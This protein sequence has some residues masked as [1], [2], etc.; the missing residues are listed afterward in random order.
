MINPTAGCNTVLQLN[1]GE[2]KSSVIAP[3]VASALSDGTKLVRVVVLKSLAGQM[4]Q[5]LAERLTGLTN[6]RIFYM[7]FSRKMK[8]GM[9][10]IQQV[11][12][13]F[14]TCLDVGGILVAQPEVTRLLLYLF[15]SIL[16]VSDRSLSASST[17]G[18]TNGHL[19]LSHMTR[20]VSSNLL[21]IMCSR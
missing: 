6:R 21:R 12:A 15:D 18:I 4:F 7:P 16:I 17:S 20:V 13:L 8:S 14:Q 1:M 10:E 11:Q 2:G 5:V 19:I 9:D 3:M